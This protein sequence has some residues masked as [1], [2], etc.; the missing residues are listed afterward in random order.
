MSMLPT[1]IIH[2]A[3]PRPYAHAARVSASSFCGSWV[4]TVHMSIEHNPTGGN[5]AGS[6]RLTPGSFVGV[7]T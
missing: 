3:S 7:L 6:K 2:S 1:A 5:T 4:C